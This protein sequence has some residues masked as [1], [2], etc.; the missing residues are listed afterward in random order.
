MSEITLPWPPVTTNHAYQ[1]L[2]NGRLRK[3]A[4]AASWQ[5]GVALIVAASGVRFPRAKLLS[6]TVWQYPPA[7]WKGDADAFW[8]IAK[9]AIFHGLGLNDY[10]VAEEHNYRGAPCADPRIVAVIELAKWQT[11]DEVR[12]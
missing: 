7:G 1:G 2:G 12:V 11:I 5:A 3:T 9:D 6:L 8:K 4:N 10:W